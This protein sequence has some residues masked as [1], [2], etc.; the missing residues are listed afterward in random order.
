MYRVPCT[1]YGVHCMV[2]LVRCTLLLTLQNPPLK[3][4]PLVVSVPLVLFPFAPSLFLH[5]FGASVLRC[6]PKEVLLHQGVNKL[7]SKESVV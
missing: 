3:N 2:Y 6:S 1:L 5:S 7:V 4:L